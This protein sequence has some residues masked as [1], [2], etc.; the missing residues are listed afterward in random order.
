MPWPRKYRNCL[1]D[2]GKD[3]FHLESETVLIEAPPTMEKYH[4]QLIIASLSKKKT[5]IQI[6]AKC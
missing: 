2:P 6:F 4:H 5:S 1:L 3:F